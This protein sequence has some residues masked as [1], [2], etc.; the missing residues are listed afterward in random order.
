MAKIPN[1][2]ELPG[3]A[4]D[5]ADKIAIDDNS[6]G[7][8]TKYVPIE[9]LDYRY[10]LRG[11]I[12]AANLGIKYYFITA[13]AR[14]AQ[15]ASEGELGLMVNTASNQTDQTVGDFYQ[16]VTGAW[17]LQTR[18]F[19]D[20]AILTSDLDISNNH[21]LRNQTFLNQQIHPAFEFDGVS[22]DILVPDNASFSELWKNGGTYVR[23]FNAFSYGE[24]SVG[25]LFDKENTSKIQ[26]SSNKL[27]FQVLFSG[28]NGQWETDDDIVLS[29][30][31]IFSL[32]YDGSDVAN[33]PVFYLDGVPLAITETSTPVGT[34][35]TDVGSDLYLNNN[36]AD[37]GTFDGLDQGE[38]FY[39]YE[40]DT[41]QHI[42]VSSN[43]LIAI[44][45][46]DEGGSNVA[47]NVSNCVDDNYTTFANGTPT[48][49]DA[50]S[51]GSTTHKA[52]TADE[53]VFV[54]GRKYLITFDLVLN[55]GTAPLAGLYTALS[56]A[57]V[58]V[59][60]ALISAAG[61]NALLY[62][63]DT[64]ATGVV[65]FLNISTATDYEVTNLNVHQL[66]A[67]LELNLEDASPIQVKDRQNGNI[68]T[69]TGAALI[70][71]SKDKIY[72]DEYAA[73]A[74]N[75]TFD[76][77]VETAMPEIWINVKTLQAGTTIRIGTAGAGE[78]VVADSAATATAGLQK[79]TVLIPKFAAGDT[80]HI[81]SDG[82]AA[83]VALVA[84]LYVSYRI[85]K[86]I[87]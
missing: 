12:A 39:N 82:G 38:I 3:S 57:P 8:K 62:T 16:W 30:D 14:I 68:G 83:W 73:I 69:I 41:D 56:G 26:F 55:S 31:S 86:G 1:Y 54:S 51:N 87:T 40:F 79:L 5:I 29:K 6:A 7:P 19:I 21:S 35:T 22:G 49:F 4:L 11:D 43:K 15:S 74:D 25:R 33:D 9:G 67:T 76:V 44:D 13:A 59:G 28:T 24:S 27:Q 46:I 65:Q 66:G 52:G 36:S 75:D 78:Q 72:Q 48:G 2:P 23:K 45:A 37:S 81:G 50:T 80:L 18:L 64:S 47:Q 61:A 10:A 34:I 53:I 70:N 42:K 58:F 20:G 84:E 77:P 85:I 32:S 60:S 71:K 17:V 63:C